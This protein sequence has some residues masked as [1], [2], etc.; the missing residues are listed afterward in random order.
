[1]S[2]VSFTTQLMSCASLGHSY[3]SYLLSGRTIDANV[4]LCQQCQGKISQALKANKCAW[5]KQE[6][7]TDSSRSTHRP[8]YLSARRSYMDAKAADANMKV[9]LAAQSEA[10]ACTSRSSMKGIRKSNARKGVGRRVLFSSLYAAG[11]KRKNKSLAPCAE[12]AKADA[13]QEKDKGRK[14]AGKRVRF[15]EQQAH[16]PESQYRDQARFDTTP[17][18]YKPGAYADRP[19]RNSGQ[20]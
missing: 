14:R 2:G 19:E 3:S 20:P 18:F 7:Y 13:E 5:S 16:R 11:K 17:S 1:M 6:M 4:E 10:R 9:M 8:G 12:A 15:D